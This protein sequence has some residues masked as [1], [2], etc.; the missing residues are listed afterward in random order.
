MGSNDGENLSIG[1]PGPLP[2]ATET[3]NTPS[4]SPTR[5]PLAQGLEGQ[6]CLRWTGPFATLTTGVAA[7]GVEADDDVSMPIASPDRNPP[8]GGAKRSEEVTAVG[9]ITNAPSLPVAPRY[10]GSTMKERRDFMRAYETF[11]HALSAFGTGLERPFIMPVSA[12]IEERTCRMICLYEFQKDPNAV[13]E[14]EWISYF[15]QAREPEQEDYTAVDVAMKQLKM[16]TTFPD[17]ASRMCQLR[18][19]MHRILDEQTVGPSGTLNGGG[20]LR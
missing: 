9:R 10:A 11:F 18:A 4:Q 7:W 16:R 2:E 1:I 5:N 12:C 15:L 6:R 8:N 20:T 13:T 19:D 14:N 17:A 3:L